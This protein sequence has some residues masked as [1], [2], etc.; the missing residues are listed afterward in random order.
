[1]KQLD[2][3]PHHPI[4]L[5]AVNYLSFQFERTGAEEGPGPSY[6]PEF[7]ITIQRTDIGEGD[8]A[9]TAS[10][11]FTVESKNDVPEYVK[12]V[13]EERGQDNPEPKPAVQFSITVATHFRWVPDSDGTELLKIFMESETP[14]LISWPYVRAFMGDFVSRT[15]LPPY[16]LPLLQIRMGP[17]RDEAA[18]SQVDSDR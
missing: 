17:P 4:Q 3:A 10:I 2:L 9:N 16:H 11:L 1:M 13:L 15:G 8:E 12:A 18:N 6:F 7:N 14:L 5:Q